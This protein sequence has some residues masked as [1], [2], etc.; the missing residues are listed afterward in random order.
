[1]FRPGTIP[2]PYFI[3][4]WK[5]LRPYCSYSDDSYTI[6]ILFTLSLS[7]ACGMP[8][9]MF[10]PPFCI[11]LAS[12]SLSRIDLHLSPSI[13]WL[14]RVFLLHDSSFIG[15]SGGVSYLCSLLYPSCSALAFQS[16]PGCGRVVHLR[17]S[18]SRLRAI[19][20]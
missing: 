13:A 15:S 14:R 19:L 9:P 17:E 6:T 8:P 5:L 18:S 7:L 3:L 11:L 4:H 20:P 1:M 2:R 16:R 10:P 12:A